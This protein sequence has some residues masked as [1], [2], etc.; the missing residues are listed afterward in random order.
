MRLMLWAVLSVAMLSVAAGCNVIG[1]F[2][3]AAGGVMKVPAE[4]KLQNRPTLVLVENY[5]NP[6]LFALPADRLG[7]DVTT[8][9][10][11]IKGAKFIAP[12]KIS[13]LKSSDPADFGK[14]NI[15]AV[16]RAVGAKQ[17]V[18]VNLIQFSV[19]APVGGDRFIGK[20]EAHVK[21]IDS[22]TGRTLWP[23]DSSDGRVIKFETKA[24]QDVDDTKAGIMED[25]LCQTLSQKIVRLFRDSTQEEADNDQAA[26]H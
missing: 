2:S 26:M 23:P 20:A 5:G 4:Y 14:M 11:D 17:V 13:D 6:D 8:E 7:R 16:G 10:T 22:D 19:D 24:T 25:Q 1:V 12:E 3:Y 21:V 15:P 18:Y 9:L